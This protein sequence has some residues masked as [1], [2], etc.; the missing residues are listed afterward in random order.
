[1][2]DPFEM[3]HRVIPVDLAAA[4]V[5][6]H[7]AAF[8]AARG[9]LTLLEAFRVA[10]R[11][12]REDLAQTRRRKRASLRRAT[13]A[14]RRSAPVPVEAVEAA[15]RDMSAAVRAELVELANQLEP[16][17]PA[18]A[19][20]TRAIIKGLDNGNHRTFTHD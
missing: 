12:A 8:T 10:M 15:E 19:A 2:T 11:I 13:A 3:L 1:M 6:L 4:A 17:S 9:P 5:G 14:T 16:T 20:Q 18:A 7:A